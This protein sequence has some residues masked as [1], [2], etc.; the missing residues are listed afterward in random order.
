MLDELL[1]L[2]H[3]L[4]RVDEPSL[5]LFASTLGVVFERVDDRPTSHEQYRAQHRLGRVVAGFYKNGC[6]VDLQINFSATE[7]DVGLAAQFGEP[8]DLMINPA[9]PSRTRVFHRKSKRFEM[10]WRLKPIDIDGLQ[11]RWSYVPRQIYLHNYDHSR[12]HLLYGP[13]STLAREVP[14]SPEHP[15]T[16]GAYVM[17]YKRYIGVYASPGGPVFFHENDRFDG[18]F[19]SVSVTAENG[20]FRLAQ[21]RRKVEIP[22]TPR[23][24][25]HTN[26]YD[27]EQ[28]DIDLVALMVR[29]ARD[30]TWWDAYTRPWLL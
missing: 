23:A 19:G 2:A 26:P 15:I 28:H 3:R 20:K 5:E 7:Y 25:L 10:C 12:S 21:D 9:L 29:G 13:F 22:Y 4:W 14:A 16:L 8:G 30:R 27:R 18:A 11:F 6:F 1:A 17:E 24:G